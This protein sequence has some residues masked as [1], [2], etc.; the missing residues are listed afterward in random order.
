G[1]GARRRGTGRHMPPGHLDH[2]QLAAAVGWK[3][4]M[5][6][7]VRDVTPGGTRGFENHLAVI[8]GH[9][10]AIEEKG[11]A[12]HREGSACWGRWAPASS[13]PVICRARRRAP[14][15]SKA[16]EKSACIR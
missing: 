6:A 3:V 7:Q 13:R 1:T 11:R 14:S 10:L 4:R 12:T 5:P 8:E 2:A 15:R 9:R 16:G